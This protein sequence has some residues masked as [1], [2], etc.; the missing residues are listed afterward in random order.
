MARALVERFEQ[1]ALVE[2]DQFFTF[3]AQDA[4]EPWLTEARDQ[5]EVVTR[6]AAA[7]A[8]HFAIG[9][10]NTVYDGIVDAWFLPTFAAATG[11]AAF[12]YVVL[13]PSIEQCVTRVATREGH[14]FTNEAATRDM[15]EQ[16]ALAEIDHRHV[17]SEP[18]DQEEAVADLII[19]KVGDESL[20][21]RVA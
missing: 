8:G 21:Y 7:A 9:G 11:L 3:L 15:Y 6:A 1:S 19:A 13:M 17:L 5:N 10:Y 20:L 4:I 18:P 12:H 14:G 16:F 2:G